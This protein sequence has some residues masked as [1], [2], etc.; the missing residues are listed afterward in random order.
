MLKELAYRTA[1]TDAG[2]A[3][4]RRLGRLVDVPEL[5]RR[6]RQARHPFELVVTIDT[7]GGYV[8][9]G[10]RRVWQGREPSAFQGFVDGVRNVLDALARHGVKATFLVSPHGFSAKG[11]TL[12]AVERV[13][14]RVLEE[15]HEIGLHLHP[16]SDRAIA[17]ALG[18]T[19]ATGTAR[20]LDEGDRRALLTTGRRLLEEHVHVRAESFRWGN[21]GL[22]RGSAGDVA[23]SGFRIDSSA[24]PRLS[25]RR[26]RRFDWRASRERSPWIIAPGLLEVPIATYRVGATWLRADPLYGALLHRAFDVYRARAPRDD[27]PFPFV[28][29]THS[30]EATYRDGAPTRTL[31]ALDRFLAHALRDEDV[32]AIRLRDVAPPPEP[33]G[34][35]A[36]ISERARLWG[37]S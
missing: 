8:A 15:G 9:P 20:E 27:A 28:L 10:E 4:L 25:D 24:V 19:F 12:L 23:A 33:C 5:P 22:D 18:R 6:P 36:S 21:W 13:L 16:T 37:R 3:I 30:T 7:E 26:E 2:T 31:A 35:T 32:R 34:T 17:A 29:M 14:S 1:C 11:R